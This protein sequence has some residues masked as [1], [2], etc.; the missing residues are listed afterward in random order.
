MTK[1]EQHLLTGNESIVGPRYLGELVRAKPGERYDW[2]AHDVGQL[3]YAASGSMYVGTPDRV[4]LLS[5]A[6][7]IWIPPRIEHWM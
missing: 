1:P 2:H 4:L 5:P 7:A 6:M 3:A